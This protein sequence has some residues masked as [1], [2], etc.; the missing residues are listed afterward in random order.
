MHPSQLGRIDVDSSSPNDPGMAGMLCPST[1]VYDNYFSDFTEPNTWREEVRSM[2]TEYKKMLG[3]KEVFQLQKEIGIVPDESVEG[4]IDETI[5]K[6]EE[7]I[8]P[9]TIHVDDS[10]IDISPIK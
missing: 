7:F 2:L 9:F 1:P 10:M 6:T 3:Y 8:I 5:Q 4:M